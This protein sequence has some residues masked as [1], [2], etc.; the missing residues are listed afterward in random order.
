M[1]YS[2]SS[3]ASYCI[4]M[5]L[6]LL[7]C[8]RCCHNRKSAKSMRKRRRS[9]KVVL[10]VWRAIDQNWSRYSSDSALENILLCLCCLLVPYILLFDS[11]EVRALRE[12]TAQKEN[13]YHYINTMSKASSRLKWK[14]L[15]SHSGWI[16]HDYI[17][18]ILRA[19]TCYL[20]GCCRSGSNIMHHF[21]NDLPPQT[22]AVTINSASLSSADHWDANAAGGWRDEGLRVLWSTREEEGRQ[23][24]LVSQQ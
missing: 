24:S 7:F 21:A 8:V 16:T 17:I 3:S 13:R 20:Q 23:V 18:F 11:K 2:L 22:P 9:M 15:L 14:K 6:C 19:V 12:E 5:G 1:A 4:V 10:Q